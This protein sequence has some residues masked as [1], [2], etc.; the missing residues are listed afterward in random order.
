MNWLKDVVRPKL[1]GLVGGRKDIPDNL[2]CKC[3]ACGQ[4]I[5][6]RDLEKNDKV[7]QH[8]GH[9]MRLKAR[10]RLSFLFDNGEYQTIELQIRRPAKVPRPTQVCGKTE[11]G[12]EQ[13]RREGGLIV[14]HGALG[15]E[16]VVVAVFNFDFMGG[17][18]GV[19]VGEGLVCR[20]AGHRSGRVLDR[21]SAPAE[22]AC[23]KAFP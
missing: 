19:G 8:C 20:Q 11:R 16:R 13:D 2:W 14:A 23:R 10:E 18:M 3:P 4:M 22:L 7:C 21:R 9:H 15:G 1:R 5:F 6:H 17:S 12:A